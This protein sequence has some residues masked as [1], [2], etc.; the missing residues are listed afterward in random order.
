[1]VARVWH[2]YCPTREHADAYEAMLKPE[3]LP[4]IS[5]KPGYR[6]SHLL[7]RDAGHEIEFITILFFETLDVTRL[8]L[9]RAVRDVHR[10]VCTPARLHH[11]GDRWHTQGR[12]LG[13]RHHADPGAD[14][15]RPGAAYGRSTYHDGRE[16]VGATRRSW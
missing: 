8:D 11:G 2:G 6:G 1:M 16:L 3:L 4:G 9:A 13:L 7:R 15:S 12:G 10:R 5:T 14:N